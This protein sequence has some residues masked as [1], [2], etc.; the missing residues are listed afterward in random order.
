MK[1]A[2]YIA[3]FLFQQGVRTVFMLSG[4]GSIHLDD[5]FAYNKGLKYICARHE[6][7]AVMMAEANAKMNENL[8]VVISTT[9]PGGT[10]AIGG[11][12]EAWVDS[13]PILVISG[14]V[15]TNLIDNT[16]RS[17][18]VQ[19]FNIIDNVKS[20]TKYA[21][22]V[23]DPSKI[24]FYLEKAMHLAKSG[25][26]GPVWLDIPLDIQVADINL[27]EAIGYEPEVVDD[28]DENIS[29]DVKNV[30]IELRKSKKPLIIVG[31][32][33]RNAG[34]SS[35]LIDLIDSLG[36]P[37][38]ASRMGQDILPYS[39][40]NFLGLGGIKGRRYSSIIMKEAD[41]VVS[42]GSSLAHPFAGDKCRAFSDSAKIM[43]VNIDEIELKKNTIRVD[44]PIHCDVKEF[45]TQINKS[46]SNNDINLSS[47]K[48]WLDKCIDLKEK[49]P[50]IIPEFLQNPIN[51][52]YLMDRLEYYSEKH[53]VFVN[54]AGSANYISGQTLK[55]DKGQ[56]EITSGAFYS[57]GLA[58]PLAIG[59]SVDDD[60]RQVIV[61]TGD[62]SIE[63]NIQELRTISQNNMNIKVFI[64][65]NGGYASIRNAQDDMVGGRYT[66]D[67]EILDFSK[68]AE[69]FQLPFILIE[70][71]KTLD[72]VLPQVLTD[73][74]PALIEVVCDRNQKIFSPFR[75]L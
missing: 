47:H 13:V 9:G 43:M 23:K 21:K 29:E 35:E 14:Q 61:V 24:R 51:S 18:G 72:T 52:Y 64:I 60:K 65:N 34:A 8:G 15:A 30:L 58:I 68:V 1:V 33:V 41:L 69:A 44:Y 42:L 73:E 71:F 28:I 57:M 16:T 27:E 11:L 46:I 75:K 55:F 50:T 63:L 7:A 62:G 45:L 19:G 38:I 4:T 59:C 32:G 37:A 70:D 67:I 3:E 66:D 36:V 40:K 74:G 22:L 25:R 17:F 54:D 56:R 31:Q 10:N 2:K 39:M 6:A 49:H 53:H 5:A 12:V 48:E 20:M 26:P